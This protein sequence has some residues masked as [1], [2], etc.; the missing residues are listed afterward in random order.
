M[1]TF[2][3]YFIKAIEHFFRI[4][5]LEGWENSRKL[6]KPST[7]S[8]V[9]ITVSNSPNPPRVWMRLCKHGK[10]ALLL[11]YSVEF[12]GTGIYLWMEK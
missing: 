6:C 1:R 4:S 9:C 5:T 10:S 12:D 3:N 8:R 11:N 7:T 2:E